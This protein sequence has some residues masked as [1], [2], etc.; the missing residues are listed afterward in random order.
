[1][2]GIVLNAAAALAGVAV[3]ASTSIA[4][5]QDTSVTVQPPAAQVNVQP[6]PAPSPM[7]MTPT[8]D[9]TTVQE[10]TP[11][12]GLITSGVVMFGASYGASLVVAAASSRDGDQHLY[13]PLAGPWMDLADR[14]T[15]RETAGRSCN[16]ETANKVLLVADGIFQ[17][18]GALQIIGGFLFPSTKV[19][20]R[21][22]K[23]SVRVT[24]T[25]GYGNVGLQAYGRF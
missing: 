9:I 3:A 22:A 11:N 18:A 20:T 14:G 5:A 13:V 16:N 23:P 10:K 1:M 7:I 25:A 17:G 19:V 24:P 8:R 12:V 15:C 2:K 6:A 21:S 4:S